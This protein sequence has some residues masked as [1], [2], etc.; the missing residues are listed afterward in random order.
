MNLGVIEQYNL[1]KKNVGSSV[2]NESDYNPT[3]EALYSHLEKLENIYDMVF[4]LSHAD[5][6]EEICTIAIERFQSALRSDRASLMLLDSNGGSRFNR[7]RG[8]SDEYKRAIENLSS[9]ASEYN[10]RILIVD[11]DI[12]D[13]SKLEHLKKLIRNEGIRTFV[14]FPLLYK[15]ELLGRVA[16]YFD[17]PHQFNDEELQLGKTI[18]TYVAMAISRMQ[19]EEALKQS[20][21]KFRT[22]VSHIPGAVYRAIDKEWTIGFISD[23]IE[24][25]TGY[26]ASDFIHN[27]VRSLIGLIHP[28][29]LARVLHTTVPS[30]CCPEVGLFILEYRIIAADDS[31]RWVFDQGQGVF[32]ESGNFLYEDGILFDISDRKRAEAK[33]QVSLKEKELLLK[34]LHHRVKNNLQIIS[35]IFSLQSQHVDNPEIRSIL[36]ESQNRISSIALIHE[37]LYQSDTIA[38]INLAEYIET[39]AINLFA[40]Y[41]ISSKDIRLNLNI[42][43]V[44]LSI[45]TAIPCGLIINELVSNCL[46]HAFLDRAS[47][48]VSIIL[49]VMSEGVLNL[50]IQDNG[51][52]VPEDLDIKQVS[53]LGLSLVDALVFQIKGE[54]SISNQNGAVFQIIFP[55]TFPTN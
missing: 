4:T 37:K 34:E 44:Y 2:L 42:C 38:N 6:I 55:I 48:E 46:K 30:L 14:V 1:A 22:L 16:I 36:R 43:D 26:P 23:G 53:S 11:A 29:D 15:N 54:L 32:D 33:L 10:Y 5:T 17:A 19:A 39:L 31:I 7:S 27:R 45:D 47:G 20:E 25:I 24:L 28:D 49:S 52:G 35:S 12:D 40:S 13:D 8:L 21:R 3:E 18:S 9:E 50:E 51:I 41:E